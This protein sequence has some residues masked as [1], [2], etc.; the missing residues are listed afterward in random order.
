MLEVMG[1]GLLNIYDIDG[2]LACY[3]RGSKCMDMTDDIPELVRKPVNP[4]IL[5]S[6][7][8]AANIRKTE[9]WCSR[10]DLRPLEIFHRH[11]DMWSF[12]LGNIGCYKPELLGLLSREMPGIKLIVYDDD[13]IPL[14]DASCGIS[15]VTLSRM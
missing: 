4:Y 7:R 11:T 10:Y 3:M 9:L 15:F 14:A 2:T 6:A 8:S 5:L 1:S 12:E 13:E